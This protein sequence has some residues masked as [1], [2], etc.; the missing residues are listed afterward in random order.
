LGL[1]PTE[2]LP[3]LDYSGKTLALK[4][5]EKIRSRSEHLVTTLPSAY[6][7]L[8]SRYG[9]VGLNGQAQQITHAARV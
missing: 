9:D 4:Q 7:Y 3:I 1:R 2:S 8:A 5:F 6:E